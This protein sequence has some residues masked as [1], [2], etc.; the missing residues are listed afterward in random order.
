MTTY[1]AKGNVTGSCG[2]AHRTIAAAE[3]CR[4]S[5]AARCHAAGGYSD[6]EL[7]RTDGSRIEGWE[8]DEIED[9]KIS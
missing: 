3:N 1:H 5:H 7:E 4:R 2:H 9:A 8:Y 6:R